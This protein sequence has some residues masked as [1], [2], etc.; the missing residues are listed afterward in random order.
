MR[1]VQQAITHWGHV[2]PYIHVPRNKEEYERLLAFVQ[3]LMDWSRH[4]E[5]ERATSL[6]N[7]IASNVEAYENQH[8]PIK[9]LSAVDMVKFFMDEHG[10]R[11]D[12]LPEIGS[13]SLM[14]KILSGERRL[15]LE[16]I[17]RLSKRFGVSP[18]VFFPDFEN[19]LN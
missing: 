11:Q 3:E 13:Q 8:Y 12:E 1:A 15:T 6:L 5:D 17:R 18:A 4:H 7:L 2:V 9:G 19:N 16:H 10:L 14:S